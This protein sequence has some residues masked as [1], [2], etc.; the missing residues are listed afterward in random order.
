MIDWVNTD[1]FLVIGHRGVPSLKPENTLASFELALKLGAAG[2]ELD[3]HRVE[4]ELV[5]IHDDL[6]DRTT[7][8]RGPVNQFTL[9][10]LQA[11]DAG[12]GEKIPLLVEVLSVVQDHHLVNV[13]L[14]GDRTG[15]LLAEFLKVNRKYQSQVVVSSF[16]YDELY[17]FTARCPDVKTAVLST[18]LDRQSIRAAKSVHAF[19]TNLS[20]RGIKAVDIAT[21][22]EMGVKVMV[23]TVNNLNRAVELRELKVFGLFTDAIQDL[24]RIQSL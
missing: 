19:S 9:Q 17:K 24:S 12:D 21:L 5:V 14:K 20:D 4:D 8:G 1:Q 16:K 15:E 18:K 7:N 22:H 13:E 3:V 10:D 23:Y 6:V 11:L 2:I